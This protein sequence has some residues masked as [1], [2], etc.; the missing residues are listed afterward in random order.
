MESLDD[1]H[2][3]RHAFDSGNYVHLYPLGNPVSLFMCHV[4][5]IEGIHAHVNTYYSKVV[6][7]KNLLTKMY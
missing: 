7:A 3:L 2:H 5:A 6:V 1:L 4:L